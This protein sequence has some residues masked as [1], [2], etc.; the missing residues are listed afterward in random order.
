LERIAL[1]ELKMATA[2]LRASYDPH[3]SWGR[4]I[5]I[6]QRQKESSTSKTC[7]GQ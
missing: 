2:S 6:N 1:T 3:I 5:E 7:Y 4:V